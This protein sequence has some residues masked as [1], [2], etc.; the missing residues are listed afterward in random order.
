MAAFS[1]VVLEPWGKGGGAGL[2]AGEGLA[3]GPLGRQG[4]VESFDLAVLPRA[5]GSDELLL[6]PQLRAHAL[7]MNRP[8]RF[9]SLAVCWQ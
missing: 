2:V 6:R 5:V 8:G 9:N 3:V 7:E 1:V 4:A